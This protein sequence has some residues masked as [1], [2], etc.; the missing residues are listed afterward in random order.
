VTGAVGAL[1]DACT[2]RAGA[3]AASIGGDLLRA[4][5]DLRGRGRAAR[6]RRLLLA[7]IDAVEAACRARLHDEAGLGAGSAR[8][9]GQLAGGAAR[10][11]RRRR[12]RHR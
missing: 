11:S 10:R 5:D 4:V 8:R 3:S 6:G 7:G 2:R 1:R 9:A 12:W